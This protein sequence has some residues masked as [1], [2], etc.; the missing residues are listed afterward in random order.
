MSFSY[1]ALNNYGKSTLPSV[2]S[3]SINN[4]IIKDPPKSITTRR[5]EKVGDTT[6]LNEIIDESLD[7]NSEVINEYARGVNPM[8]SVSFSNNGNNGGQH[9]GNLII[10]GGNQGKLPYRIM[11]GG[12]F[13]PPIVKPQ[14]LLPVSRSNR[15]NTN[16]NTNSHKID[17]TKRIK[18]CGDDT[19]TKEVKKE[20]IRGNI[21]P[22]KT[23]KYETPISEP[24]DVRYKVKKIL[25]GD[26]VTNKKSIDI[27]KRINKEITNT[28]K[29][30]LQLEYGTNKTENIYKDIN[31][32][33]VDLTKIKTNSLIQGNYETNKSSN[34]SSNVKH[35][36]KLVLTKNV[37]RH[38][39]VSNKM[40]RKYN[41]V[42]GN[43]YRLNQKIQSGT[44]DPK[45]CKPGNDRISGIPVLKVK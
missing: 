22:N 35:E 14:D 23:Y 6:F 31:N 12:A 44:F 40:E 1:S 38:E 5:I 41:N 2:E 28:T 45:P 3:W 10:G 24:S 7:R 19:N 32:G 42:N 13:R 43:K 18:L 29:N 8:V 37:P 21:K 25:N 20:I 15:K 26:I 34:I 17:Y 16:M 4:N 30:K 33:L 11:N 9:S 36:N 39:Y 27:I